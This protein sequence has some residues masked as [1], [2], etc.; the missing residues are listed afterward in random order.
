MGRVSREEVVAMGVLVEKGETQV[1]VAL[2]M[3]VT[4]GAVRYHLRREAEGREDGR[5]DK[6]MK[7]ACM[8]EAVGAFMDRTKA[9]PKSRNLRQLY[10]ELVELGYG[11]SYRSVLRYVVRQYG[12][13]PFR[14]SRRVETPPGVQAQADW[15][16]DRVYLEDHGG[17]VSVHAFDMK[18]S[19]SR[20]RAVVWSLSECQAAFL[21]CHNTAFERLGGIPAAVRIDNLK[22]GVSRGAGPTAVINEAYRAYAREAG[23]VVDPCRARSPK[24]KGKVEREVRTVRGDL[25]LKGRRFMDLKHLQMWTDRKVSAR[26]LRSLCPATGKSVSESLAEER[27]LLRPLP[28]RMPEIM[29]SCVAQQVSPDCLVWFERRQYSVPFLH[30]LERV[31]VRGYAGEVRIYAQGQLVAVHPRGTERRLVIDP[32][33]YEGEGD[34]RVIPPVPLGKMGKA[35]QALWRTDVQ[36]HAIDAYAKLCE[37]AR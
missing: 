23:F 28:D 8:A 18:L 27:R 1:A 11:G 20:G 12:K 14:P 24:D 7:A 15:H 6:P 33:H 17:E 34:G 2:R 32:E 13:A 26:M 30:V 25:D 3:G 22:T 36:V 16:E 29:D 35:M 5:R 19:H 10:E 4:E 9:R 21:S 31:E 37:V